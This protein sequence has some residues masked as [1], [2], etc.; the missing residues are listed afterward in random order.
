MDARSLRKAAIL[1]DALDSKSADALLHQMGD[2]QASAVRRAVM[3]LSDIDPQ[4]QEAVIQAFMTSQQPAASEP[5]RPATAASP[6]VHEATKSSPVTFTPSMQATHNP[7]GRDDKPFQFL[8][9]ADPQTVYGLLKTEHPQT[10]ALVLAHLPP[11][12]AAAVVRRLEQSLRTDVL[13]RV[14]G[15]D[16]L[17][18]DI[19]REVEEE[20]AIVFSA[21]VCTTEPSPGLSS[22]RAILA[23][24]QDNHSHDW[25]QGI[26]RIDPEMSRRIKS[27]KSSVSQSNDRAPGKH[28]STRQT[29]TGPHGT[30][31]SSARR[32]NATQAMPEPVGQ[33]VAKPIRDATSTS[34]SSSQTLNGSSERSTE[35]GFSARDGRP[36]AQGAEL[37]TPAIRFDELN[38]L[39][40]DALA[41]VFRTAPSQIA[42]AALAGAKRPFV[43]R[44]LKQLP[45]KDAHSLNRKIESIGPI[46]LSDVEFA[47]GKLAEIALTLAA[48]GKINL[49]KTKRFAAA[50]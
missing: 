46:R 20:M 47:Q 37:P 36:D 32:A 49:A 33:R 12:Q 4:E 34:T 18:V 39:P 10:A 9:D 43:E 25:L 44:L 6:A 41:L 17:D 14:A 30:A 1:I 48:N 35:F 38:L 50:A 29:K 19:L 16:A 24:S 42:L 31:H 27:Q 21:R 3:D 13:R 8:H 5:T 7:T 15:L 40:D 23:A 45:S 2:E 22:L 11:T 26:E 28:E